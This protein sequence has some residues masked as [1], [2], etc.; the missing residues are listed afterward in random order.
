MIR[1]NPQMPTLNELYVYVTNG[2][3]CACRH[4]WIVPENSGKA[5]RPVHFIAPEIFAA[6]VEEA[7]PLGLNAVKWTGGGRRSAGVG[8]IG[9]RTR[10]H[11]FTGLWPQR[12]PPVR[13]DRDG[14]GHHRGG[15]A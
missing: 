15:R 5:G 6:A 7:L 2:C 10:R 3:N 12:R 11:D 4:C 13:Y 8:Q 1:Q 14:T 9:R